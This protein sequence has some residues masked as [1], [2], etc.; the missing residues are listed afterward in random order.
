MSLEEIVRH[1]RAIPEASGLPELYTV[2]ERAKEQ[3]QSDWRLPLVACEAVGGEPEQAM[4]LA[5]AVA[6][7]MIS[8]L[9]V[10]DIL[11]DDPRGEHLRRG[12]GQAANLALAFEAAAFRLVAQ[13]P[14]SPARQMAITGSLAHLGLQSAA[15]Q[16]LDI[17]N[18]SGEENYWKV[19]RTKSTPFYGSALEVGA[20]AGGAT[21]E[22]ARQMYELGV[23]IGEILQIEDDFTDAFET[24][25]NADWLQGRNNLLILYA[26]TAD[27]EQKDRFVEILGQ[28]ADPAVLKE[29]Q[30]ILFSSGAVSYVVY[31][32]V[33]RYQLVREVA[34][35][36]PLANPK[37]LVTI[38]DRYKSSL[39]NMLQ[40]LGITTL[41]R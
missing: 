13:A 19:I 24:P 27:H 21:P 20:I 36:I 16:V 5:A 28:A 38:L 10:D 29:A 34:G 14:V 41:I 15:G 33:K 12:T 2:F 39:N 31:L 3:P 17:Q 23:Q 37:P 11:D 18:L 7:L 40:S 6:C 35:T 4:P 32:L 9:L 25:A 8:I 30:Q 1:I 22:L 26:R